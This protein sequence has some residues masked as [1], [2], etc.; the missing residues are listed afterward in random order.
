MVERLTPQ[1]L[2]QAYSM[3]VFP[4]GDSNNP[5]APVRWYAPDPRCIFDLDNFH[6]PKRLARTYRQG[7]FEYKINGA[8]HEVMAYCAA[9]EDTWITDD[10]FDAY[11]ELYKMGRAH[12]VEAYYNGELAGGLYGVCL[13]GAFMGE[14]M[15]HLVTDASKCA[16]LFLVER[17]REREFT[18][19]DCQ[20]I[21]GHLSTFGALEI[22]QAEYVARLQEAMLLNR[23]LD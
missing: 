5:T 9:R 11:T 13:G 2:I 8:W 16:L 14:S 3:G 21:T 18:L 7:K 15:F 20:F 23:Q 12:S 22:P 17:M 10:I 19:L 1:M 6:V 4:M